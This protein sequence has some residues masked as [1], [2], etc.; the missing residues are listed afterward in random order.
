MHL[1]IGHQIDTVH[2]VVLLSPIVVGG[3]PGGCNLDIADGAVTTAFGID[4]VNPG[5]S[6]DSCS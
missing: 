5:V 6:L 2:D 1:S 3:G 4:M